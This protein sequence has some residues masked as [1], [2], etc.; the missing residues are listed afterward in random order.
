[1]TDILMLIVN[2]ARL[3]NTVNL[4]NENKATLLFDYSILTLLSVTL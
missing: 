3:N 1:M 2:G 4:T